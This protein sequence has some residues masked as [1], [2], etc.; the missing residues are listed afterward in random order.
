MSVWKKID[1]SHRL[2]YIR[3]DDTCIYAREYKAGQ[4]YA[5]GETNQLILNFKKSPTAR[6][7]NQWPHRDRGVKQFATEVSAMFGQNSAAAITG[8]P[9][10]KTKNDPEYTNRFEDA[11]AHLLTLKPNLIVEWPIDIAVSVQPAHGGGSRRP[12]EI[13]ANYVWRGFQHGTP[14]VLVLCDDVVTTGSHFRA[15][16]DFLRENGFVGKVVGIF[17]AR[18]IFPTA[19]EA[20]DEEV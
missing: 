16:S 2:Y 8:V 13:K 6:N 9:S 17:W 7:T 3:E 5:A 4:G 19:Q 18:A 14:E 10:S 15:A 20:F 11:F 12:N 1:A